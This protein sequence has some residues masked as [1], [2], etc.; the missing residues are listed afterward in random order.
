MDLEVQPRMIYHIYNRGAHKEKIFN[1]NS[2]YWRFL[3][4]LFIANG[5]NRFHWVEDI[6]TN[7][8]KFDRGNSIVNIIAYCLMPNHYHILIHEKEPG[9][10]SKFMHRLST[11]YTMYYNKKYNHSGT[12]FQ[13]KYKH[14][15]VT[16]D[17]YYRYL[18]QYIHLNPYSIEE[19]DMKKESKR[20]HTP[21]MFEYSKKYEFSSYKDFLYKN[22]YR[23]QVVILSINE[24]GPRGPTS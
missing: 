6:A 12:I 10:A 3:Y 16:D 11:A 7:P 14:R 4:L 18:I 23:K 2:D 13:G 8:F 24:V 19:P 9:S 17:N 5:E 15:P 21:E 20:E 1:D 22:A